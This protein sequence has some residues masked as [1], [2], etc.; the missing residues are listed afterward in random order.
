RPEWTDPAENTTLS[1]L[2]SGRFHLQFPDG[3]IVLASPGDYALWLFN[4]PQSWWAVADS[5]VGTVRW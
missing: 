4:V 5:V 1:I 3:E 2:V